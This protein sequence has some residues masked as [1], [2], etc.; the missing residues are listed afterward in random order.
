MPAHR[1]AGIGPRRS[2]GLRGSRISW[3]SAGNA[4]IV[5]VMTRVGHTQMSTTQLYASAME[6]AA[7]R[8]GAHPCSLA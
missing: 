1:R 2:R 8:A 5:T 4:D 7:R 3:L 6:D